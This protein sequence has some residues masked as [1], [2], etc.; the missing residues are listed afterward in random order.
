MVV[1]VGTRT[2]AEPHWWWCC[3]PPPITTGCR[4]PAPASTLHFAGPS[5]CATPKAGGLGCHGGLL[6]RL[7][8]ETDAKGKSRSW[9]Q[10]RA[11]FAVLVLMMD[12]WMSG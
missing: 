10:P 1:S 8:Q 5:R 11:T 12:E 3:S 4:P 7:A 6:G 9:A 2:A